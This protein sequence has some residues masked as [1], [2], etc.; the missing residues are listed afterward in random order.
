[1]KGV[2]ERYEQLPYR[3]LPKILLNRGTKLKV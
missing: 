3:D 2:G 1:M